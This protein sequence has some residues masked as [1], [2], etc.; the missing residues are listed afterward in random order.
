MLIFLVLT[1]HDPPSPEP[2]VPPI[3][4]DDSKLDI[5]SV[6]GA[7]VDHHKESKK[8]VPKRPIDLS[9]G[10]FVEVKEHDSDA[11]H[12]SD[13][14]SEAGGIQGVYFQ[15]DEGEMVEFDDDE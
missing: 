8:E 15:D 2:A 13:S 1:E 9:T 5:S 10:G 11:S 14:D 7:C 4:S 6:E 12:E 3:E